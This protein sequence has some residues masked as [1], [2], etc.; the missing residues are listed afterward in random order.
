MIPMWTWNDGFELVSYNAVPLW[1]LQVRV[2][3]WVVSAGYAADTQK[4]RQERHVLLTALVCLNPTT[5]T[6]IPNCPARILFFTSITKYLDEIF[7]DP[8]DPEVSI[9]SP[10]IH[11]TDQTRPVSGPFY[12]RVCCSTLVNKFMKGSKG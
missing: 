2:A 4:I 7:P 10:N 8:D 5:N 12:V 9:L 3:V 11:D 1:L 6:P